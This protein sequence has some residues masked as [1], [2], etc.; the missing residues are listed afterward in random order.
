MRFRRHEFSR[1][2]SEIFIYPSAAPRA[3]DIHQPT[4]HPLAV[5]RKENI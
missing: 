1:M 2:P 4:P 3:A 5:Y